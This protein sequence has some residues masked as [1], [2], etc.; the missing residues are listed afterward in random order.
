[1]KR[2]RD[3]IERNSTNNFSNIPI[4]QQEKIRKMEEEKKDEI[5]HIP[6]INTTTNNNLTEPKIEKL[7]SINSPISN[8]SNGINNSIQT[9]LQNLTYL[10]PPARY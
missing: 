1:M 10:L 5:N 4:L 7:P 2:S 3:E 6:I 8:N 9:N